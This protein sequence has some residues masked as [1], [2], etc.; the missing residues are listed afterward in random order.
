MNCDLGGV[1]VIAQEFVLHELGGDNQVMKLPVQL[2]FLTF[3]GVADP[4]QGESAMAIA[5]DG[6]AARNYAVR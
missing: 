5:A 3:G 6:G 4:F 1:K 2:E